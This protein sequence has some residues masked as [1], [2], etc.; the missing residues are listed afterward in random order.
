MNRTVVTGALFLICHVAGA[1]EY[2]DRFERCREAVLAEH[3]GQIIKVEKKIEADQPIYEF[4]IRDPQGADWDIECRM[5]TGE[6]HEIE[7]EVDTP[8]DPLFK[9]MTTISERRA[10]II[11]LEAF[12]GHIVEVEYEVEN[13]GEGPS[14]YEFDVVTENGEQMKV[15]IDAANGEIGEA[16]PQIWQIGF[17]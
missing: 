14:V 8:N 2:V 1:T 16:N 3:A 5:R 17:E 4:D 15:E 11:A 7:R 10:R 6:I 13:A 9:D 12:P